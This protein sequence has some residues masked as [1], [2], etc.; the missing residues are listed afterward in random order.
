MLQVSAW[1]HVQKGRNILSF[2]VARQPF[3]NVSGQSRDAAQT[4]NRDAAQTSC[5]QLKS[6]KYGAK[7]S[8][9]QRQRDKGTIGFQKPKTR[10]NNKVGTTDSKDKR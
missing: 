4:K 8:Q 6:Q 1:K 10:T 9:P 7:P 3:S 5:C 2:I